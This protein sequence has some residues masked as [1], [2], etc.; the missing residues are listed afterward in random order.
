MTIAAADAP[1]RILYAYAPTTTDPALIRQQSL[2]D[3]A[4]SGMAD[5]DL[6][7]IPIIGKRPHF[8]AVLVG[9]DG[10]E[11]L[12]SPDPLT[13]ERLFEII[14]AMPMRRQEMRR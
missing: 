7:L 14:D 12:H 2:L 4:K 8:E 1:H 3:A 11:K 5:R 13:P 9:K 6:V 10:G